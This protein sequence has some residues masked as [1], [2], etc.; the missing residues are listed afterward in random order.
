M[1]GHVWI[2][3]ILTG[4]YSKNRQ[5]RPGGGV[6]LYVKSH[7]LVNIC[8][9]VIIE[10]DQSDSLFAEVKSQN[11]KNIIVGIIYR[12]PG[13]DL[14]MF[15]TKLE[16]LL[17]RLNKTTKTCFI[18]GDCNIDLG[19]EDTISKDFVNILQSSFFFPTINTFTRV[20]ESSKTIIDNIFT[21]AHNAFL[22]PG[23]ILSDV[24]DHYP[25][26]LF[27]DLIDKTDD[28]HNKIKVKV[29]KRQIPTQIM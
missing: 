17:Y 26:V 5:G 14:D 4:M 7:F 19:K 23:V 1:K 27:T 10:D 3:L 25:I 8:E 18:L 15:K 20:T 24:S 16:K 21:N 11:C 2:F 9:N 13:S 12:P 22:D 29:I 28:H 6:C